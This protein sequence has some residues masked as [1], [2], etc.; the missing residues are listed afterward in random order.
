MLAFDTT[1]TV[2]YSDPWDVDLRRR[3]RMLARGKTCVAY[4]YERPDNSTFRYRVYNMTQVLNSAGRAVSA[5]YFFLDDLHRLSEIADTADLLVICR[6]RFDHRVN[7]LITA[8]RRRGK[9]VLFDIDDLVFDTDY[10]HLI[11]RTLDMDLR[12]PGAWDR[13]F[14]YSSR[15][16]TT[17][18]LCDGAITTNEYLAERIREYAPVPTSIVPNFMNREQLEVSEPIFTAKQAVKIDGDGPIRLGYFSGSPTHNRDFA[19]VAPALAT[20]LEEDPRLELVVAGYIEAGAAFSPFGAR[21]KQY[22]FQD[23][24]NLQRLIG[25]VEFNLVPLQYNAFTNCKSEL[26][27][28]EAAVV[29]TQSIVSPTYTYSRAVRDGDNGYVAPA[30]KWADSIR[31]AVADIG[32]YQ[33]MAERS[34]EDARARYAWFNQRA[35]ILAALG[36]E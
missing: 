11:Q 28:F 15:L 25:S 26:K 17:L 12:N 32:D 20:L 5:S 29:G 36:L 30:H 10:G 3:M 8:F 23:F 4:F 9:R 6:A 21:V 1:E 14:A 7:H 2:P 16:G 24:I 19:I 13:W 34:F 27:Y 33:A 18:R 35:R 31:R 22:P